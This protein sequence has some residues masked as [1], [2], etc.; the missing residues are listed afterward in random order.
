MVKGMSPSTGSV[1]VSDVGFSL[2]PGSILGVIGESGAGKSTLAL[3]VMGLLD[4]E[5]FEITGKIVY[6]GRDLTGLAEREMGEV[7]GRGISMIFQD[8]VAS[9]DPAMRVIDQV[10]EPLKLHLRLGRREARRRAAEYLE[11]VG[12]DMELLEAAPYAH[13]LS[14]GQCQR[15]MIAAALACGP[16]VLIA[17][18]PTSS[19]DV[20][21]QAQVVGLL[22]GLCER[23]GIALV[24]ISHDLPLV[25]GIADE[26][27]VMMQGRVVE[28][29]PCPL[30]LHDPVHE[31]TAELVAVAE[32]M[33]RGEA[34]IAPA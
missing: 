30:M 27:I 9:L 26:L 15:A 5:A 6:G 19:L 23:E 29:G 21:T 28:H 8:P 25:A 10:A 18:E 31:Y 33:Q 13:Q 24:F 7:R 22:K 2:E 17:D 32:S 20:T 16:R 3:A 1:L 34:E 12:I 4:R 14:G 11:K